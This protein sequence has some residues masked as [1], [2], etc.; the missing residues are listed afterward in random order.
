[1]RTALHWI[2]VGSD[3]YIAENLSTS[4]STCPSNSADIL[5]DP[6]QTNHSEDLLR[7]GPD[8][9]VS[10]C[11]NCSTERIDTAQSGFHSPSLL[12]QLIGDSD[13]TPCGCSQPPCLVVQCSTLQSMPLCQQYRPSPW[14]LQNSGHHCNCTQVR[15]KSTKKDLGTVS[16][17]ALQ[18]DELQLA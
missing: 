14:V 3:F 17:I 6:G 16:C 10:K 8:E 2:G 13:W 15:T 7:P 18:C 9:T 12:K 5:L 4:T 1:M 11:I